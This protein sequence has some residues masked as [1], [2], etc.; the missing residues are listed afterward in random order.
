MRRS[1]TTALSVLAVLAVG[2]TAAAVNLRVL[3]DAGREPARVLMHQ[4]GVPPGAPFPPP[5][6]DPAAG[7]HDRVK[8]T[9]AQMDVLRIAGMA[10]VKP[11][12]VIAAAQ[13][14][15]TITAA[16]LAQVTKV[17]QYIGIDLQSLASV[18]S[19]PPMR[20]RWHGGPNDHGGRNDDY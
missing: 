14:R 8:L 16:E 1:V 7:V 6:G 2:A 17:A 9:D 20:D 11:E 10:R 12:D 15:N 5:D 4:D 3:H 13:G 18:T 19:V